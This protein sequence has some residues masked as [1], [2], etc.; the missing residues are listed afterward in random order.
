MA[1]PSRSDNVLSKLLRGAL[2][3]FVMETEYLK[4]FYIFDKVLE[5]EELE[6]A[7]SSEDFDDLIVS[8]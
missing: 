1:F 5:A 7:S 2:E 8:E 6:I 4:D 3:N